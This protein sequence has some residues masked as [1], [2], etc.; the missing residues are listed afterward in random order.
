MQ[1]WVRR[2]RFVKKT[3]WLIWEFFVGQHNHNEKRCWKMPTHLS[4]VDL[5]WVGGGLL[6]RHGGG[7]GGVDAQRWPIENKMPC[8]VSLC[9]IPLLMMTN[10][11]L[12]MIELILI[13]MMDMM[14][15]MMTT[16]MMMIT[17]IMETSS[18]TSVAAFQFGNANFCWTQHNH[19]PWLSSCSQCIAKPK[20]ITW[21]EN[22]KG[23][24][25]GEGQRSQLIV[26]HTHTHHLAPAPVQPCNHKSHY[27]ASSSL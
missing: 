2:I 16:T 18:L 3:N 20:L 26:G 21:S 14:T 22:A 13:L 24:G 7:E 6:P 5:R 25:G 15:T 4:F 12:M 17:I 8:S 23:L 9:L 11:M 1:G 10:I 27:F 19:S